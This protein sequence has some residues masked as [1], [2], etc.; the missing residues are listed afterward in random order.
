MRQ[1]R[2]V[3]DG[4]ESHVALRIAKKEG[5]AEEEQEESSSATTIRAK[6]RQNGKHGKFKRGQHGQNSD[7]Y[8]LLLARDHL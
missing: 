7:N 5:G 2:D 1:R 4:A 3:V 6:R 8:A